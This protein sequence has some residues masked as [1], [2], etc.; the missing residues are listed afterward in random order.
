MGR[1]RTWTCGLIGVAAVS[2]VVGGC[3][4][5][6]ISKPGATLTTAATA[7][8]APTTVVASIDS[9]T[10]PASRSV[11]EPTVVVPEANT[12][13]VVVEPMTGSSITVPAEP[14][15][16]NRLAVWDVCAVDGG[17]VRI[18]DEIT[19]E[20]ETTIGLR[21]RPVWSHD[22]MRVASLDN[23]DGTVRIADVA[24]GLV[25]TIADLGLGAYRGDDCGTLGKVVDWAPDDSAVLVS[26]ATYQGGPSQ[27]VAAFRVDGSES[28]TLWQRTPPSVDTTDVA[29]VWLADGSVSIVSADRDGLTVQRGD[30][31]NTFPNE[32]RV[33]PRPTSD[34]LETISISPDG[35]LT[36]IGRLH[37]DSNGTPTV[38]R[39]ASVLVVN[40][41]TGTALT[42]SEHEA[43]TEIVFAPDSQLMTFG[44]WV[45]A[46]DGS[47]ERSLLTP[48]DVV[49]HVSWSTDGTAVLAGGR[50][51]QR[52]A[53]TDGAA[54]T[55]IA[56][57]PPPDP[58]D[59]AG[60]DP[61]SGNEEYIAA[62]PHS[63]N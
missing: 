27:T 13:V 45:A 17:E 1:R 10:T 35:Q 38:P 8:V 40:N 49:M 53:L 39:S 36:A 62:S 18:I 16:S 14:A 7:T 6:P 9:T 58:T 23:V 31:W 5:A 29:A 42:V 22:R 41:A 2:A 43:T 59:T 34:A 54:T 60:D 37:V 28:R 26:V 25:T 44:T 11:A 33:L 61:P 19:G 57:D 50:S 12:T 47:G 21:G 15:P 63:S 30:P 48:A 20:L 46:T 55:L 56:P 3:G 24:T 52:L 4:S 32:T 51:L